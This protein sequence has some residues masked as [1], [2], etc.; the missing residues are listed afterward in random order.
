MTK[1]EREKFSELVDLK[2]ELEVLLGAKDEL[3][4]EWLETD[5]ESEQD[6]IDG[7]ITHFDLD[8]EDL[9]EDLLKKIDSFGFT[10]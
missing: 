2:E 9:V 5:D 8:I 10:E 3:V 4:E 1:K 7:K 6:R